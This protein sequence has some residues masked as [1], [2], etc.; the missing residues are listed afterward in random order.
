MD[1]LLYLFLDVCSAGEDQKRVLGN[2]RTRDSD[3]C[4]PFIQMFWKSS[5]FLWKT[6][7]ALD[8]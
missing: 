2:S 7:S 5:P 3:S 4:E 8:W 6:V 1:V